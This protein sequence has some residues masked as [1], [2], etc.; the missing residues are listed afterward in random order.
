MSYNSSSFNYEKSKIDDIIYK[1]D[2]ENSG[3]S[4]LV[5]EESTL[6]FKIIK[7]QIQNVELLQLP[8]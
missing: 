8:W 6:I 1:E 3:L 7:Y 4:K 2:S 5:N